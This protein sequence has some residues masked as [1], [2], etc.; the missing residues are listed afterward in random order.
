MPCSP[1]GRHIWP[2][3]CRASCTQAQ[4]RPLKVFH[5]ETNRINASTVSHSFHQLNS[6]SMR[7]FGIDCGTECTGYGVVEWDDAGREPHLV[8]LGCGGIR[9]PKKEPLP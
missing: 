9:L 4:A 1:D 8:S 6:S 2:G 3:A 5:A 7:V